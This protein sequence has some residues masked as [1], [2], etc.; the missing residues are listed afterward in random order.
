MDVQEAYLGIGIIGKEGKQAADF[1]ILEFRVIKLLLLWH[2]RL[3]YKR[4]AVLS[5]FVIHRGLIIS[6][7]QIIFSFMFYFTSIQ[8]YNGYL[9]LGYTTIY[10]MLPVFS[11][12][13]DEDV[14]LASVIKFPVLYKI[15]QKGRV[16]NVKTFVSWCVKSMYQGSV[17]M[18]GAIL[19][20]E[21]NF[22]NIVSITFTTLIFIEI[23]NVYLEVHKLHIVMIISFISTIIVYLVTMVA[24]RTT[25]DVGYIFEVSAMEKISILT[26]LCWLPFYLIN[27][28]YRIYFP[29]VHERVA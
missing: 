3:S 13:F 9:M 7:I 26:V 22:V 27:I 19:L 2:G 12:V 16:L 28:F 8:I 24:L 18:I 15:L 5:Q 23:L 17:I 25:F 6:I 14:D 20:F 11:I 10:T 29:E 21:D 1:S 4:S